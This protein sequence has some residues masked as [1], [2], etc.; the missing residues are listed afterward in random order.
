MA[1]NLTPVG[2]E[3]QVNR[4]PNLNDNQSTPDVAVLTDG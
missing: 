2:S 3:I 1:S 4:V